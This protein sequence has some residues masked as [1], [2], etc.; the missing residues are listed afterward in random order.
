MPAVGQISTVG[1][2]VRVKA[3][4]SHSALRVTS[5]A[6]SGCALMPA[7]R[8]QE[9]R[10]PSSSSRCARTNS[11]AE[12]MSP[13]DSLSAMAADADVVIIGAGLAGAAAAWALTRRGRSVVLLEQFEPSH[14]RGSSHGSARIVRRVYE[15]PL[16]V[17]LTG[18]A[19]EL[20]RELELAADTQLLRMY[21]G[22][23]FGPNRNVPRIA[24]VLT[25]RSVSFERLPADEA[26][27]RWPGMVFEGDVIYTP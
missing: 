18:R 12:T 13:D 15:D 17:E 5:A 24:E 7:M 9:S 22:L 16:Y 21:G 23:D 19:F 26:A 27:R 14:A 2:P 6:C 20:W 1:K 10:S 25:E 11:R 4:R 3:S 8:N